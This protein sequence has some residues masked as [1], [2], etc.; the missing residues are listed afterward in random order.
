MGYR[1]SANPEDNLADKWNSDTTIPRR[2]FEWAK[3]VKIDLID[4]LQMSDGDFRTR[5]EMRLGN[6]QFLAFG[7]QNTIRS[8]QSLYHH[9]LQQNLGEHSDSFY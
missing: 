6:K 9:L 3:A 7:R 5:V 8:H 4:S 2:F 1:E